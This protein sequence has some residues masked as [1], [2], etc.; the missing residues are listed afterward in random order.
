MFS[1]WEF[2]LSRIKGRRLGLHRTQCIEGFPQM[3]DATGGLP[4]VLHLPLHGA[5]NSDKHCD[6]QNSVNQWGHERKL[7]LPGANCDK[8]C[9]LQNSVNPWGHERKLRFRGIP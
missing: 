8:H 1:V 2:G 9:D 7:P 6:L 3:Q 4:W 5:A